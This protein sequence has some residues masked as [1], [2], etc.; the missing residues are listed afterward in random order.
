MQY[1]ALLIDLDGVLRQW[2]TNNDAI[3]AEA[4]LP[5]GAIFNM[6]FS[7]VHLTPAITGMVTDEEWRTGVAR[8]LELVHQCGAAEAA[9]QR[10]SKYPGALDVEALALV[11]GCDERVRL[12]L[13][14]NATSR[15]PQ[16]LLAL[17]IADRFH[18]VVNSSDVGFA[19]PAQ[20]FYAIALARAGVAAEHALF[21]DDSLPNVQGANALGIRGHHYIGHHEMLGFLQSSGVLRDDATVPCDRHDAS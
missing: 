7:P 4:H 6:A 16:D 19:K 9:V 15:L 12:V 14:T 13:V 5:L 2:R 11:D 17:G 8:Q 21:I 18:A 3:E 1:Q 20:E 10:W